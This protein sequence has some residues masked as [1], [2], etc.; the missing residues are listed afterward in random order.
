M[1]VLVADDSA[2]ARGLVT[3]ALR[4]SGHQVV[5]VEDGAA[6]AAVFDEQEAPGLAVLDWEMPGLTGPDVCRHVRERSWTIAPYLILLTSRDRKAD[7]VLGLEAGADDYLT[8]P[9]QA[10]ELRARVQVGHR[11][12][13]LQQ[14]LSRRVQELEQAL[15]RVNELEGLLPICSYCKKVRDDGNYWHQVE[16][17][18][19]ARSAVRFSHGVCPSCYDEHLRPHLGEDGEE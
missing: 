11:V 17:Y 3:S 18:I 16:N 9:F 7:I 8:K 6:A 13:L 10:E 14:R 1:K 19:G 12:V 15:A 5:V 2:V 4:D